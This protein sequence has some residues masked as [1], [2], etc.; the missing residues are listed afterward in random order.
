MNPSRDKEGSNSKNIPSG[1]G[2]SEVSRDSISLRPFGHRLSKNPNHKKKH[3]NLTSIPETQP[4]L[5][6]PANQSPLIQE[7]S[8]DS[9]SSCSDVSAG[10]S[11]RQSDASL[12]SIVS[13]SNSL[14]LDPIPEKNYLFTGILRSSIKHDKLLTTLSDL[15][16]GV[17]FGYL[18]SFESH[19]HQMWRDS[20]NQINQNASNPPP[21]FKANQ[22]HQETPKSTGTQTDSTHAPNAEIN[23]FTEKLEEVKNIIQQN[24]DV[25]N[26]KFQQIPNPLTPTT[27][28]YH[29]QHF[30]SYAEALK[31]K[32]VP[33]STLVIKPNQNTNLASL[34]KEI[35][36]TDCP[37]DIQI[38]RLKMK[39]TH[40]E[41]R[42]KS[43][44]QKDKLKLILSNS[45]NTKNL[46][47]VE[48][49]RPKLSKI[50]IFNILNSTS[51][52]EIRETIKQNLNTPPSTN[53]SLIQLTR[54][55]ESRLPNKEHW[56]LLLPKTAADELINKKY[57]FHG[58]NKLLV[59]KFIPIRRC[60]YC[61]CFTHH[62]KDCKQ[63]RLFCGTC[64][65]DHLTTDCKE[66]NK[67]FCVNC[68][69]ENK[70]NYEK[71]STDHPASDPNCPSFHKYKSFIHN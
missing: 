25:L 58:F 10:Q 44:E 30:P 60:Q 54:K 67:P 69:T 37:P 62:E 55:N 4:D 64:A 43:E 50:I 26:S 15:H 12:V 17:I 61:Q 14:T 40:L 16:K 31:S 47:S 66:S 11:Q 23:F 53:D 9:N 1:S 2:E 68:H 35:K 59:K 6:A 34:T 49:K 20:M 28:E 32:P 65:D 8:N 24:F 22:N 33:K 39:K 46:A 51:E 52:A 57:I 18:D 70:E 13:P 27:S 71:F 48:D 3:L 36:K 63:E 19:L 38:Q 29:Q 41:I 56:V 42:C 45:S 21:P 5:Q 7:E